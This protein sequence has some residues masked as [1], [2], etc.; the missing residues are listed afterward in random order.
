MD[1][2]V[3]MKPMF[4][5]DWLDADAIFDTDILCSSS[6]IWGFFYSPS[7]FETINCFAF[8]CSGFFSSFPL[9]DLLVICLF[10]YVLLLGPGF[11]SHIASDGPDYLISKETLLLIS[12]MH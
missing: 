10:V 3:T 4:L 9:L 8:S 1:V 5:S 7:L 11:T 12:V 2:P 6:S